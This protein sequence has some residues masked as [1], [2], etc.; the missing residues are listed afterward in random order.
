LIIAPPQYA[1]Y[2]DEPLF[3]ET[4]KTILEDKSAITPLLGIG[5]PF[6]LSISFLIFGISN[7]VAIYT[8]ILFGVLTAFPMFFLTFIITN[9]KDLSLIATLLFQLFPAHIRWS[10]TAGETVT[11]LFFIMISIFLCFLYYKNKKTSLLWLAIISLAFISQFRPE[12]VSLTIV[13]IIGLLL[14]EKK[15]FRKTILKILLPL[16]LAV[17]ISSPNLIHDISARSSINWKE[18]ET[19]EKGE[20]YGFHNLIDNSL[21]YGPKIFSLELQPLSITCMIILG[22]AYM[23]RKQKKEHIVLMVWLLLILSIYFFSYIQF[24][25]LAGN[26]ELIKKSRLFVNIYPCF[27]IFASYG[28]LCLKNVIDPFFRNKYSRIVLLAIVALLVITF[29]PYSMNASTCFYSDSLKLET[30]IAE[31]AEND[32][33]P[34]C[35]IIADWPQIFTSTTDMHVLSSDSFHEE[36]TRKKIFD[37]YECILIYEDHYLKDGSSLKILREFPT[38]EFLVYEEGFAKAFFYKI[39]KD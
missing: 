37:E 3:I 28:V 20:N 32:V 36:E 18:V 25:G 14:F 6:I 34:G 8:S 26:N 21:R 4:A 38:A 1:R 29:I 9:R 7:S 11:S 31:L 22:F 23:F 5:W 27:V 19:G 10:S 13:F 39:I 2:V 17:I 35:I 30:K 15:P 16:L 12:N 24:V 33:N